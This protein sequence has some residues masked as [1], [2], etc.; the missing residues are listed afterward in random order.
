MLHLSLANTPIV[1]LSDP[2]KP[3]L[4]FTDASKFYYSGMLTQPSTADSNEA[5]IKIFTSEVPL[6]SIESQTQDL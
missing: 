6:T 4:L 1:Q 5:L 2:N 3:Y